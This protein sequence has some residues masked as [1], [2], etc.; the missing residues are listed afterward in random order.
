MIDDNGHLLR[1]RFALALSFSL[2]FVASEVFAQNDGEGAREEEPVPAMT[3]AERE[4]RICV[5]VSREVVVRDE[6]DVEA[7]GD[8]QKGV[9]TFDMATMKARDGDFRV[10]ASSYQKAVDSFLAAKAKWRSCSKTSAYTKEREKACDQQIAQVY[11]QWANSIADEALESSKAKDF[12]KAIAKCQEALKMSDSI[13]SR[14]V[15]MMERFSKL[16]KATLYRNE[17]SLSNV[18]P[19][20]EKRQYDIE[21]LMTQ[22]R[23]LLD[24]RQWEKARDR[25]EEVLAINPYNDKAIAYIRQ[26][27]MKMNEVGERRF[28]VTRLE[29]LAEEQW[30]PITPLIPRAL[31]GRNE[32]LAQP[33]AKEKDN[34]IKRKL[35]EI[36]IDHIEFEEVPIPVVVRYL[37]QRSK[38]IDPE[39]VGVNMFLRL[40]SSA[41]SSG[42]GSADSEEDFGDDDEWGDEPDEGAGGESDE[43]DE[44][45]GDDEWDSFDDEVMDD[46]GGVDTA[47]VGVPTITMV[48]DDIPLG[49]AIEYICKA[50]NLKYRVEKYAVVIADRDVLLDDVET[51]IYPIEQEAL[52]DIGADE[53]DGAVQNYFS[54]RGVGFPGGSKVVYDPRIS[55]L[56][57][58]NT[59]DE[60]A[61][62]EDILREISIIDP[63]VLVQAK[64]VEI[65]QNDLEELGFEYYVSRTLEQSMRA[66]N[67]RPDPA[68][69]PFPDPFPSPGTDEYNTYLRE[70]GSRSTWDQNDQLMRNVKGN[71]A[72]AGAF[73]DTVRP[74][75]LFNI[76]HFTK[77]GV[78][79]QAIIHA[80]NQ[81]D[82]S[83]ILSTP[84]VTTMNGQEAVIRMITEV[85]YPDSWG[86]AE[87]TDGGVFVGST[88]EFADP[89]ELGIVLRVTPNVDAD[90]YTIS[91]DMSPIIQQFIGWT[92]YS[93]DVVTALSPE[94]VTNVIRMPIIESRS[95]ETTITIYDGETIVLGGI[96]KDNTDSIYDQIPVLG[97]VPI[98]GRLFQSRAQVSTKSNLL[99]FLTCRLVNPDG[100]PIRER[101]L[102]G[103][104][105]FRQ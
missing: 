88:P 36:I 14:V 32:A 52:T 45:G 78:H 21:V 35:R 94:G 64:F 24:D 20:Y 69:N 79:F 84:R 33:V 44:S 34:R 57:A 10:A 55:R 99:I 18:D 105:S 26:I 62:I 51:R 16:K 46:G 86:E 74:D 11:A 42:G 68:P 77:D 19:E 39:K 96:I 73:A 50:A 1:R 3:Q 65:E 76:S 91:L 58:T 66:A 97:D 8:Y 12:D 30:K 85:Y 104:P 37:K 102:R 40:S 83:D 9:K 15:P 28:D 47:S 89:T 82:S 100:S 72:N 101:E 60:L 2:L 48:V 87:V 27:Y 54:R 49:Q 93:Y 25:F 6:K 81:A 61:K 5:D 13:K 98:V 38:D 17:I 80:L 70:Q 63:Q 31:T 23:M 43:L 59:P 71:S 103:L 95:V 56:I 29:R 4:E 75:E 41:A 90:H 92:D 53:G 67:P 7:A 22:G